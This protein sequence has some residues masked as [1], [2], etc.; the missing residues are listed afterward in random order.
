MTPR[1]KRPRNPHTVAHN[2]TLVQF[3]SE[4]KPPEGDPHGPRIGRPERSPSLPPDDEERPE[5]KPPT[6]PAG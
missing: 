3:T 2:T 5:P 6:E 4:F 1:R